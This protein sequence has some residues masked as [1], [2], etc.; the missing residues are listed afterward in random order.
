[1]PSKMW[2]KITYPFP[3]FNGCTVGSL[4]MG[5]YFQP[6]LYYGRNYFSMVRLKLTHV[7]KRAPWFVHQATRMTSHQHWWQVIIVSGNGDSQWWWEYSTVRRYLQTPVLVWVL[8]DDVQAWKVL[9]FVHH[10]QMQS[11]PIR[12]PHQQCENIEKGLLE[13]SQCHHPPE[14]Q[15]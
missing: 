2:D 12:I 5:K 1:M 13:I 3:N 10:Q 6:T 4:G 7:S 15:L 14:A 11:K 8:A 9:C